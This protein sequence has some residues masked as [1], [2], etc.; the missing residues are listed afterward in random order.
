MK[1]HVLQVEF[2]EPQRAITPQQ[3][4]VMYDGEICLGTAAISYPGQSMWELQH[5]F[6]D[7]RVVRAAQSSC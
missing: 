6:I 4:F 2:E 7:D 5:P 3:A 1:V